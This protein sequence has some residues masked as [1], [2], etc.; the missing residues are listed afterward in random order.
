MGDKDDDNDE[1][2]VAIEIKEIKTTLGK[3]VV[4]GD[5]VHPMPKINLEMPQHARINR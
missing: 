3:M 4:P 1:D 5:V 2:D